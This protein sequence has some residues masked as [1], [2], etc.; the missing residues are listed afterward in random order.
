MPTE[1]PLPNLIAAPLTRGCPLLLTEPECVAGIRRGSWR[2]LVAIDTRGKSS[3]RANPTRAWPWGRRRLE[4]MTN[5][6]GALAERHW[7]SRKGRAVRVLPDSA[8]R[9]NGAR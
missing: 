3:A 6:W 8:H 7:G 5:R 2:H 1:P 4:L 9:A